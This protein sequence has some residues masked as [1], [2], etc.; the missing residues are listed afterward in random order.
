[1]SATRQLSKVKELIYELRVADAMNRKIITVPPETT[2]S[3]LKDLLRK[4]KISGTPVVE[5]EKLVGIIS[6]EDL[7]LWLGKGDSNA[8]VG[9][10]MTTDVNVL[11]ADEGLTNGVQLLED[12]GFGR[13]PVLDRE[14]DNLVGVLTKGNI[15]EKLLRELEVDYHEAESTRHR[16]TAGS[17]EIVPSTIELT[18]RSEVGSDIGK[19]GEASSGLK[20][21][22]TRLG[23]A[24]QI[25]RRASI[26]CYEAEMNQIIFAK[27]GEI[28]AKVEPGLLTI[29]IVDSGPGIP[30]IEQAMQPG[31]STASAWVRE[32]GFGAG[33]G[34]VNIKKCCDEMKIDSEVG[35]GTHLHLNINIPQPE[36]AVA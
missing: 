10:K 17:Q 7:I 1:M 27:G 22:L 21:M 3:E 6:I 25:V 34:L 32:L 23:I 36:E 8:R 26:A 11:Y 14:T 13:I 29:D 15:I 24:P 35:K 9:D 5:N 12:S 18:F 20:K 2:M 19:A 33:M 28:S 30:D 31:W 16:I 4:H